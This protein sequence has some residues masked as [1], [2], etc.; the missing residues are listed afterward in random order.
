MIKKYLFLI[1]SILLILALVFTL[2]HFPSATPAIG[3]G[4]FLF[5]LAVAVS[6]IFK[7]QRVAYL[8]DKIT[9]GVF[10]RNVLADTIGILLAMTLAGLLGRTIVLMAIAQIAN[11]VIKLIA[12]IVIGLLSGI[13]AGILVNRTWGQM[14]KI[15]Y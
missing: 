2:W 9:H 5:G 10:V 4:F 1:I 8:Q 7:K 3:I 11:E 15:N 14:L 12:G 13:G 6:A